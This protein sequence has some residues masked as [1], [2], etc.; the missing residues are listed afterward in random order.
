[1]GFFAGVDHAPDYAAEARKLERLERAAAEAERKFREELAP[2]AK[3][4][5]VPLND[6]VQ[7]VKLKHLAPEEF[8]RLHRDVSRKAAAQE[9]ALLKLKDAARMLEASIEKEQSTKGESMQLVQ[10]RI[11]L[12]DLKQRIAHASAHR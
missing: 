7:L 8:Q 10:A 3:K 9:A 5:G 1:M 11:Q 12:K 6:L 2:E 4:A